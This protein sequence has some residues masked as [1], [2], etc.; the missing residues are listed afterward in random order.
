MFLLT[1][2]ANIV[3]LK[4]SQLTDVVIAILDPAESAAF[5]DDIAGSGERKFSVVG[6]LDPADVA[7][8]GPAA[9]FE[10]TRARGVNLIVLSETAQSNEWI[11]SQAAHMHER[12]VRVRSL[13][14]FY[15][16]WLGK[17]PLSELERTGMWFDIKDLH[18]QFY[19]RFKRLMDVAIALLVAPV[20]VVVTPLVLVANVIANRGPFFF[21]QDRI[22]HQGVGFR[23]LKFRTMLPNDRTDGGGLWTAENDPRITPVGRL[24]RRSHLDEL[25]QVVNVLKGDLSIVGPRPEQP[26]YVEQLTEK[27]PFYELRHTV[28]PGMTGWAQVKYP[29]GASVQDAIEKLQYDLYY[30]RHQ[31]LSLDVRVCGR[32]FSGILFGRGR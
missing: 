22:G 5:E 24:L 3:L 10:S 11:V 13:A 18:E 20:L 14:A 29:Y 25:P 32:T 30:L 16:E 9:L 21:S 15:D 31:S 17:L 4:S 1:S 8:G 27:V 28:R 7:L 23:I 2:F 12:G 26:H 6:T 19:Q